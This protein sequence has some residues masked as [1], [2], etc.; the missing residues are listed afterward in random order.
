MAVLHGSPRVAAE[1]HSKAGSRGSASL[2]AR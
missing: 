2:R 1:P